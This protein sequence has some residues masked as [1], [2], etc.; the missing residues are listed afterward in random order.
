MFIIL[1][2]K[3]PGVYMAHGSNGCYKMLQIDLENYKTLLLS[4]VYSAFAMVLLCVS[5]H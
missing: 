1:V 2:G 5:L 4:F 3:T